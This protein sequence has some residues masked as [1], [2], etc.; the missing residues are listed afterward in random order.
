MA[1]ILLPV[2]LH[3]PNLKSPGAVSYLDTNFGGTSA[4][5]YTCFE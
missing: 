3:I 2:K 4:K 5:I 1:R